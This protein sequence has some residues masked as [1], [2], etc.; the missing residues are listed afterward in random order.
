M[1]AIT[2]PLPNLGKSKLVEEAP[3][4]YCTWA[5]TSIYCLWKLDISLPYTTLDCA[6]ICVSSCFCTGQFTWID[7]DMYFLHEP[8][9][10]EGISTSFRVKH[11]STKRII[12]IANTYFYSSKQFNI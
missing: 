2:Y 8:M 4:L 10:Q 1:D 11:K 5:I 3:G 6:N 7:S 9:S 12:E